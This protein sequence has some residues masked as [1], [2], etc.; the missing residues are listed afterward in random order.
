M[1][2]LGLVSGVNKYEN[3]P[4]E[5]LLG[6]VADTVTMGR[7]FS[8]HGCTMRILQDETAEANQI[9]DCIKDAL[10]QARA[11]EKYYFAWWHSSHGSHYTQPEETDGLGEGICCYDLAEGED[12][13]WNKGFIRDTDV[14]Q[15]LNQ[16]PPTG[17]VE[18]GMDTCYSGGMDRALRG[19]HNRFLHSPTNKASS[20]RIANSTIT[21][22]LNSNIILWTACQE[23]ETAADAYIE[24]G[25]HGAFTYFFA[26][27]ASLYPNLTR[28]EILLSVRSFLRCARYLQTP[29]LKAWNANVQRPVGE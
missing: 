12:G 21:Q 15:L 2:K 18:V 16:F 17:I 23:A 3:Y 27:A 1:L 19:A 22:G 6:C 20:R 14:R 13:E 24:A 8:G 9:L 25:F 11:A 28:L 5:Y 7:Y 26:R 10:E 4:Q 29:R